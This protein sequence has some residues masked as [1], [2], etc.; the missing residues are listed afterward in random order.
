LASVGGDGVNIDTNT[1]LTSAGMDG[2]FPALL[3]SAGKVPPN[4]DEE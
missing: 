2:A 1:G 4:H 3:T